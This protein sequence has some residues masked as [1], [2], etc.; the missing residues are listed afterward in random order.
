[1]SG[2]LAHSLALIAYGADSVIEL[3][4]S[5]ALLSRLYVKV[6]GGNEGN[7]QRAELMASGLLGWP[8]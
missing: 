1:M 4:A 6:G 7:A 3:V 2:V 5:A 8:Y